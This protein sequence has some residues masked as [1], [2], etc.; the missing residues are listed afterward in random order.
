MFLINVKR[1]QIAMHVP[2]AILQSSVY[3]QPLDVYA[4]ATVHL[5]NQNAINQAAL[6][7]SAAVIATTNAI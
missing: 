5:M 6:L 1:L 4:I 7:D 3:L 2:F